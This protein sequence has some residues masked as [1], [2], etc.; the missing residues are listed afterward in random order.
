VLVLAW[1]LACFHDGRNP[2]AVQR[3][4]DLPVIV[5]MQLGGVE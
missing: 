4:D 2:C 1:L 3:Y 5:K